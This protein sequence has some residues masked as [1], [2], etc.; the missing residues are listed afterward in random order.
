MVRGS[1][2]ELYS[3]GNLNCAACRDEDMQAM[4]VI[5]LS[6]KLCMGRCPGACIHS[7]T[8]T[9]RSDWASAM[10]P[11]AGMVLVRVEPCLRHST[12]TTALQAQL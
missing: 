2:L 7:T 10:L 5:L 12:L 8:L 1:A 9:W 6:F 3:R 4:L 11:A